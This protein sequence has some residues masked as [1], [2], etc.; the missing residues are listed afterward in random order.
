[1]LSAEMDA[2]VSLEDYRFLPAHRAVHFGRA[3]M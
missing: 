2:A 3:Y 1:M